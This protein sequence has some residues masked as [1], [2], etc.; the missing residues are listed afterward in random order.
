MTFESLRDLSFAD[1]DADESTVGSAWL[2]A[3]LLGGLVLNAAFGWSWADPLAA[4][5]IAAFALKEG[6]EAWQRTN[7]E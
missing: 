1:G 6:R 3:A 7:D 5:A 4:L 2:S